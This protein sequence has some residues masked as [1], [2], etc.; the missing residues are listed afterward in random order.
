MNHDTYSVSQFVAITNQILDTAV[1]FVRVEGEVSNY[2]V[3]SGKWVSFRLKDDEA[4]LECFSSIWQVNTPI[5]D[6]MTVVVSG[7]PKLSP[8]WGK[9]SLQF[10]SVVPTGEGAIG[11]A[12]ELLRKKLDKAGLFDSARKRPLPT[13]PETIG[14]VSSLQADGY[15]DFVRIAQE[16]WPLAEIIVAPVQ[17]QGDAAPEQIVEA[18]TK[19]NGRHTVPDVVALVR[20][21]GSKE[22]LLAFSDERVVRAVA[23]SRVPVVV[24]VGHE[25][26]ICLAQLAADVQAATPTHAAQ[27]ITPSIL[28]VQATL[29][30]AAHVFARGL[31]AQSDR[32]QAHQKEMTRRFSA[33]T[34]SVRAE[35]SLAE[36]ALKASVARSMASINTYASGQRKRLQLSNP[37]TILRRGYSIIRSEKGAVISSAAG[38]HNKMNVTIQL[39]D[40]EKGATINE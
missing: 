23:S 13:Y 29:T 10:Q 26:D 18:I 17:V 25:A 33:I 19:L 7:Q 1:P 4:L 35:N 5:E 28:D 32:L 36:R 8:K 3:R 11:R 31:K 16:R 40:G 21:G 39:N 30:R 27:L 9:F 24:G 20:G 37:E 38:L 15:K 6:G 34:S 14:V 2:Q 12:L 22:D